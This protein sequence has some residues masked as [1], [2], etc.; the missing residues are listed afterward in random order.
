MNEKKELSMSERISWALG[1]AT[2]RQFI[3]ALV[4]TYIL[5]FMTDVFGVPA[6]AAG[7]IMTAATVWDAINDPIM[8]GLA[9][10]TKSRWGTY[11][12]YLLLIPLPLSIVSVLLFAAP[13]LSTTGKIVYAAVLYIC[14]GMLVTAIEIPY[15]AILPTMSQNEMERNDVIS[16]ATF[17]AS[18]MILIVTSFTTNFVNVIGGDNPAKGYM[19]LVVIGAILMCITSWIAFAKCKERHTV[20]MTHEEHV[21]KSA[22]KLLKVK[23]MYPMIAFWCVGCILFQ[24]I[25][26]SSVYYCMYY[27]MNPGLIATYMLVISI[28]GMI[29]VMVLMPILLRKVKG[30]MKKAVTFT[31][32][33]ACVC[34]LILFFVGGKSIPAL[35]ILTFIACM[36]ST[37]T[38]AFRPMTVFGMT[39]YVY[40]TT[41]DQLN[42]TISAIGGFSYKC[43][44][45]IS[46]AIL[47]GVLAATGYIANAIGQEPEAVLIG[48]NS[49]RF[50]VPL[51]ASVLYI[52][53]IQFYPE[54][55]MQE[56]SANSEKTN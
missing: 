46:N 30:S 34:Y 19:V 48:I 3:T 53:F 25:M 55:K 29:G 6:A 44:T 51:A 16:L 26:S 42:G 7:I 32:V 18:I 54:K 31:Q 2:G 8:G 23:E 24:I 22:G 12:P 36:F 4:S 15:Y 1:Q 11:R 33:I 13:D 49:V 14:Y 41:G 39:D 9:D 27:L 10:R 38:N 43:G 40:K 52:I 5:I 28:S 37:M 20:D 45:A 21:F 56:L 47:A 35:Y 50:L 17:I